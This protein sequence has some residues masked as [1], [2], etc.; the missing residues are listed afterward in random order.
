MP[1]GPK[2]EGSFHAFGKLP[3]PQAIDW[4]LISAHWTVKA[5]GL[6]RSSRPPLYPSDHMPIWAILE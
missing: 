6:D 5:A 4:I 2:G 3:L 1:A